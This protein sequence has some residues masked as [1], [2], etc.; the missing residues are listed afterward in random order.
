MERSS[1]WLFLQP[2]P[3]N[4]PC[5]HRTEAVAPRYLA[6][7]RPCCLHRSWGCTKRI[8]PHKGNRNNKLILSWN[9]RRK[10]ETHNSEQTRSF[11]E[12]IT[13][14]CNASR[15]MEDINHPHGK[16]LL[17]SYHVENYIRLCNQQIRF[18]IVSEQLKWN[19][20]QIT[21]LETSSEL[22]LIQFLNF[23]F[24]MLIWGEKRLLS[25]LATNSNQESI[26]IN[27]LLGRRKCNLHTVDKT[28]VQC[29]QEQE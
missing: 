1:P 23:S 16:K 18:Y 19:W 29:E 15:N 5:C 10:E 20:L 21:K 14:E 25:V 27:I 8:L 4:N 2:M 3:N 24:D 13:T 9:P 22:V 12:I 7:W 17:Q 26:Y 6:H 28:S 11:H